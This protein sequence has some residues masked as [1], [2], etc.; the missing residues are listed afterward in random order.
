[1]KSESGSWAPGA[2]SINYGPQTDP[3][4]VH[5]FPSLCDL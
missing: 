5:D 4:A 2:V 3:L 1:M